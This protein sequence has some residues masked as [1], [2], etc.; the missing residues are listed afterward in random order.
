MNAVRVAREKVGLDPKAHRI[1]FFGAG[2]S[3]IGVAK[4]ILVYFMREHGLSEQE[5]KNVFY[6][7][8][9]KG[10]VTLDRGDKLAQ[11]KVYF[12]RSDN[13]QQQ[14]KSLCEVID[15]VKPT[16]LIGL[17]AQ[18]QAFTKEAI[19]KMAAY[20]ELPIIFPLSNP[21]TNAECTFEQAMRYTDHRVL[22]ASGTAFP[23]FEL[24]SGE[25]KFAGQGNNMYIFPGFGLGAI[26]AKARHVS[27]SMVYEAAKGL[28]TSLLPEE[29]R[30]G[31]LYPALSR[32]RDVS[33]QVA[34]AVCR[35]A[36]KEK[37]ARDPVLLSIAATGDQET[38][39]DFVRARMWDPNQSDY[40][41]FPTSA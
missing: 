23:P 3:A 7:V 38:L 32:I 6:L 17:S 14:F 27:D 28:S 35:Q 31:D 41:Q 33:A 19:E 39:L 20:N 30:R 13:H 25:K 1:V 9:S 34:V 37:L 21:M 26:L 12:A 36:V 29:I 22:F 8:D 24:P 2:S 18:H 15:Y 5:A 4:Q 10:L 16:A 40:F 11:H